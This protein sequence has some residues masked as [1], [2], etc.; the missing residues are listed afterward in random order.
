MRFYQRAERR[1][2]IAIV[3]PLVLSGEFQNRV[4]E[5]GDHRTSIVH[6][7][8]RK[9]HVRIRHVSGLDQLAVF[10]FV[11]P[12]GQQIGAITRTINR[13]LALGPAT[14]GADFFALDGAEPLRLALFADRAAHSV[15]SARHSWNVQSTGRASARQGPS[16]VVTLW[17]GGPALPASSASRP[18]AGENYS[19]DFGSE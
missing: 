12:G 8:H 2:H 16:G 18:A 5:A 10:D 17:L 1:H 11:A 4:C 6:H 7:V 19:S 15:S 3:Q 9:I 13:Y 14:D